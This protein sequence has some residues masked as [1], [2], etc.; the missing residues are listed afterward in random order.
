[1]VFCAGI[2][3]YIFCHVYQRFHCKHIMYCTWII[4]LLLLLWPVAFRDVTVSDEQ[5]WYFYI[6]LFLC[7]VCELQWSCFLGCLMCLDSAA[8][9]WWENIGAYGLWFSCVYF[10]FIFI[11]L[12]KT[13][14]MWSAKVTPHHKLLYLWL[15]KLQMNF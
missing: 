6:F 10:L 9:W 7:K 4:T 13:T 11:F 1:M 15:L 12:K 5:L 2:L 14:W 3:N 8:P